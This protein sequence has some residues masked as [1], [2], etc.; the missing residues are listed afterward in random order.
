ME[1]EPQSLNIQHLAVKQS[2]PKNG[3]VP[4]PPKNGPN[5]NGPIPQANKPP[6]MTP[7]EENWTL[8]WLWLWSIPRWGMTGL[9]N[10]PIFWVE[11]FVFWLDPKYETPV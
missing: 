6:S 3:S 4:M 11:T 10:I 5:L 1:E 2:P 9:I 8:A 7:S